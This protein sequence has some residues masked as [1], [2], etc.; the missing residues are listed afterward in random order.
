MHQTI[1]RFLLLYRPIKINIQLPL[2]TVS[3]NVSEALS[4]SIMLSGK[5]QVSRR[6]WGK[7]EQDQ[8][9]FHGP[10][11]NK[12]CC[13]AVTG[14][15]AQNNSNTVFTGQMYL[16]KGDHYQLFAAV[17]IICSFLAVLL[18]WGAIFIS[19]IFIGFIYGMTQWHFQFYIKEITQILTDLML[20]KEL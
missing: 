16:S 2:D 17:V 8:I 1:Q 4:R 19:P 13:F 7:F 20:G 14:K 3:R 15:L 12:Q 9:Q 6:Y 5:H 11:A 10:R 18:R